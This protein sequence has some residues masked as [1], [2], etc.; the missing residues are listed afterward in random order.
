MT[1]IAVMDPPYARGSGGCRAV[2]G[3]RIGVL[4]RYPSPP[5]PPSPPAAAC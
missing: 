5:S 2:S 4:G 1:L 3:V